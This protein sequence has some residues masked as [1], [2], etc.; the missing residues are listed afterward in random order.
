MNST[1]SDY[2]SRRIVGREGVSYHIRLIVTLHQIGKNPCI[3]A[4]P[5]GSRQLLNHV[6]FYVCFY[7][8]AYILFVPWTH[9]VPEES[10][11]TKDGVQEHTLIFF[12]WY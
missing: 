3:W 10:E 6:K 11:H 2:V 5:R 12:N 1:S 8:T 7:I 4:Q 9:F